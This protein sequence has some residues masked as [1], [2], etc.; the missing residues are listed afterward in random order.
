MHLK[1]L[2]EILSPDG[3]IVA[4]RSLANWCNGRLISI[5]SMRNRNRVNTGD[6]DV[7]KTTVANAVA[8][9]EDPTTDRTED[10][11]EAQFE[12]DLRAEQGLTQLPSLTKQGDLVVTLYRACVEALESLG[13]TEGK[14]D[15]PLTFPAYVENRIKRMGTQLPT[16][17]Q[18][19]QKSRVLLCDQQTAKEHL[20]AANKLRAAELE[21]EQGNLVASY[22]DYE[23]AEETENVSD[24][25]TIVEQHGMYITCLNGLV[26][27]ADRILRQTLVG[28]YW[29]DMENKRF[30][31]LGDASL[32]KVEMHKF[33]HAH[34][35]AYSVALA[36]TSR[37]LA[38]MNPVLERALIVAERMM[39]AQQLGETIPGEEAAA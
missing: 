36:G 14:W 33:D 35:A 11:R 5:S 37:S 31:L 21:A 2:G 17:G 38:S 18:I 29:P 7:F 6:P 34:K 19:L 28:R 1:I 26:G 12:R 13:V 9:G 32:L 15:Y 39:K 27:E 20:I 24:L 25:F 30:V 8:E 23:P 3:K 10:A 16:P 4:L 22:S